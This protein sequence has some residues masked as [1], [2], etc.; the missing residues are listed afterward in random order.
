MTNTTKWI[1][2]PTMQDVAKAQADE[3]VI[4]A[5]IGKQWVPW[6]EVMGWYPSWNFRARPRQPEK[7]RIVL[8]RALMTNGSGDY[9]ATDTSTIDYSKYGDFICW[10]PGEEVVEVKHERSEDKTK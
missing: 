9:W 6:A 4:E 5:L 3:W 1:D 2:L 7:K 10:L 8:R